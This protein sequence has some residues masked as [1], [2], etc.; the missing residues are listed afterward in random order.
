MDG[1]KIVDEDWW[2]SYLFRFSAV[3]GLPLLTEKEAGST[4][5]HKKKSHK[6][7]EDKG[8][9]VTTRSPTPPT[10]TILYGYV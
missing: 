4:S 9:T 2:W 7:E 10:Y 3:S 5:Q 6:E 1:C 8:A